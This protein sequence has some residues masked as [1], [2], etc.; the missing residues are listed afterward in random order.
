MILLIKISFCG[1]NQ[2]GSAKLQKIQVKSKGSRGYKLFNMGWIGH[3][4]EG[5]LRTVTISKEKRGSPPSFTTV[6]SPS[7]V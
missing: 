6:N 5:G 7:F 4:K 1:K 2:K 3:L